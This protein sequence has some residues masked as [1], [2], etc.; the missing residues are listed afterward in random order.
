MWV[1]R[2]KKCVNLGFILLSLYMV[3]IDLLFESYKGVGV[4]YCKY[5]YFCGVKEL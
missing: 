2:K 5:L 4:Y 3:V 1:I